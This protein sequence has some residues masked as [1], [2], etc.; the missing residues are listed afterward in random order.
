MP[1]FPSISRIAA[2]I[3]LSKPSLRAAPSK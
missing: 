3:I 1:Q 2:K